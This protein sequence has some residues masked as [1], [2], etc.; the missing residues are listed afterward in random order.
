[1]VAVVVMAAGVIGIVLATPQTA[2]FGW[3]AYAPLSGAVFSPEGAVVV[4]WGAIAGAAA[5]AL[6]LTTLGFWAGFALATSRAA[7]GR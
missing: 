2:S 6:G 7:R 4:G 1:M 5:V 3:F